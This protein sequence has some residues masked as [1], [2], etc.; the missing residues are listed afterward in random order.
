[1][2][3]RESNTSLFIFVDGKVSIAPKALFIPEFADI[4]NRD[5][6]AGKKRA[7]K[8]FAY[9]YFM[10]DYK[11]EY[12]AYGIEKA[13]QVGIDIFMNRKY[14]P[15]QIVKKAIEKYEELQNTAS[16]KYLIA[17]RNRVNRII[18]FL[19]H[20]E[21]EDKSKDGSYKNPFVS[22]EKVNKILNDLESTMEKLEKWEKKVFD[23]EVDMQIRGGGVLN[24][25]ENPEDAKWM[26]KQ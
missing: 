18:S 14:E 22:I 9:V 7:E 17:I 1:M 6:S 24:V 25:F 26:F 12:N 20:A 16:M 23:E 5:R 10:G 21:V 2:T 8:E 13:K 4:Y 11:S 19:D 3:A 15:D